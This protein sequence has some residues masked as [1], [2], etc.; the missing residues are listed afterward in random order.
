MNKI[1]E[2]EVV[3]KLSDTLLPPPPPPPPPPQH[4]QSLH[5]QDTHN[6]IQQSASSQQ[7]DFAQPDASKRSKNIIMITI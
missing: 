2:D 1:K 3:K 4:A 5:I 7:Q 6:P